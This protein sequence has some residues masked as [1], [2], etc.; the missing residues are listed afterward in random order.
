VLRTCRFRVS[1]SH[2]YRKKSVLSK[3]I[4]QEQKLIVHAQRLVL[5]SKGGKIDRKGET[6]YA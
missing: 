4:E 6:L 2:P 3:S 1:T 5:E